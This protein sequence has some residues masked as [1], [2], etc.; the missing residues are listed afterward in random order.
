[1]FNSPIVRLDQVLL[2]LP[3]KVHGGGGEVGRKGGRGGGGEVGRKGGRG[4]GGEG[5]RGGRKEGIKRDE[6][7]DSL[8][9]GHMFYL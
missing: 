4:G 7:G 1:M 3:K 8:Q 9:K 2:W 6:G 5:G